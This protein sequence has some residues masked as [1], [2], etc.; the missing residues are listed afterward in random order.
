MNIAS[1]DRTPIAI[2]RS[3]HGPALL[4]V[5]GSGTDGACWAP[6]SPMFEPV[7]TVCAMDRRGHG[8][9]GDAPRYRIENEF[10]DV[11]AAVEALGPGPVDVFGHS[12]GALCALGAA[13]RTDKI[14]RLILYEPPLPAA[15]GAYCPPGLIEE[16][17]ECFARGDADAATEAFARGAILRTPD[18]IAAMRRVAIWAEFVKSAP[19]F[20]R[21]LEGVQSYAMGAGAFAACAAPTLLLVGGASPPR[22]RASV[23][24]LHAVLPQSRI[25]TLEG[26]EHA[27]INAAPTLL[28]ETVLAFLA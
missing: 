5:H 28:A 6:I 9:S 23:E 11:A 4:L 14:R 21:E 17:R 19:L 13:T 16:M 25:A 7:F 12:Y 27:A 8:A 22:Y 15:P 2:Y 26:Q 10:N 18:E 3:G 24:A 20:L 1:K